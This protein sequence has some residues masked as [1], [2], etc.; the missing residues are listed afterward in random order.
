VL[1]EIDG[2]MVVYPQGHEIKLGD[3]VKSDMAESRSA[4]GFL[5]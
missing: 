3:G 5:P 2:V 4:S 1:P